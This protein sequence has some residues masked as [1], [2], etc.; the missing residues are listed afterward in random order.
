MMKQNKIII[1]RIIQTL[2]KIKIS[3]TTLNILLAKVFQILQHRNNNKI[4][5]SSNLIN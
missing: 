1:K 5:S 3:I 4:N 2:T